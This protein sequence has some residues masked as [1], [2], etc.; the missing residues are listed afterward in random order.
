MVKSKS[1]MIKLRNIQSD[2][3]EC[4]HTIRQSWI[5]ILHQNQIKNIKKKIFIDKSFLEKKI[6]QERETILERKNSRERKI[7]E[8]EN[9]SWTP[10]TI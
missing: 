2:Q 4:Q 1:W 5:K 3:D 7:L 6:N 10:Q 9:L 8:R